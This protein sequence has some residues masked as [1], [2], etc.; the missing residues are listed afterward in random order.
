M[1][2]YYLTY[3]SFGD[4]REYHGS[5]SDF[6]KLPENAIWFESEQD[7]RQDLAIVDQ[8]AKEKNWQVTTGIEEIEDEVE[9]VEK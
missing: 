5:F 1:K 3:V 4:T 9:G 8:I 6:S 7:A 2:K